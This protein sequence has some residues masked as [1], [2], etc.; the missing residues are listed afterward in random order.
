MSTTLGWIVVREDIQYYI[1]DEHRNTIGYFVPDYGTNEED[2]IIDLITDEASVRGGRLMLYISALPK[3]EMDYAGF[4]G[5]M[6][7]LSERLAKIKAY[8]DR[9][10]L[11]A[12]T[13]RIEHNSIGVGMD[14]RFDRR[15]ELTKRSLTSALSTILDEMRA[16][17]VI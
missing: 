17:N 1:Y 10:G 3:D 11:G 8:Q 2:R 14:V 16:M 4:M 15:V 6:G 5:W 12:P 13:V 9:R 7:S